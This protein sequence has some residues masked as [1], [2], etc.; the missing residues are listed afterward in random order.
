MSRNDVSAVAGMAAMAPVYTP[1][2][3]A[4]R[5]SFG[6]VIFRPP[7]SFFISRFLSI[8]ST[9]YYTTDHVLRQSVFLFLRR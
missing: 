8:S 3:T 4:K 5:I 1:Q 6:Q 7:K 2:I 9:W